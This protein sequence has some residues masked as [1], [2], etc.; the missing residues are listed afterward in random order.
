MVS[1]INQLKQNLANMKT[2]FALHN[3]PNHVFALDAGVQDFR[4]NERTISYSCGQMQEGRIQHSLA[5]EEVYLCEDCQGKLIRLY[6]DGRY[7][8]TQKGHYYRCTKCEKLHAPL[9]ASQFKNNELL[10]E[11]TNK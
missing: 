2:Y 1:M 3:N 9:I 6:N 7:S 10:N 5:E 11:S 8:L 4:F